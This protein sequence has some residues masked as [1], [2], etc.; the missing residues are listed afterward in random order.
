[1]AA[2]A[3]KEL[4]SALARPLDPVELMIGLSTFGVGDLAL[5][6]VLVLVT[7]LGCISGGGTVGD[8]TG[9]LDERAKS[10]IRVGAWGGDLG[11]GGKS[12]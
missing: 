8:M 5:S 4:S 1:M 3:S 6:L 7:D 10:G 11:A 2:A 9:L 12:S